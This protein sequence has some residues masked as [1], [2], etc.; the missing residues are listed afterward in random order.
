MRLEFLHNQLEVIYYLV[1]IIIR[2]IKV[3]LIF[4]SLVN[5]TDQLH[6]VF[7]H[8]ESMSGQAIRLKEVTTPNPH[9][10]GLAH[11]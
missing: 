10:L 8:H 1:N 5:S 11:G 9:T 7:I 6:A 2:L 4:F 3:R